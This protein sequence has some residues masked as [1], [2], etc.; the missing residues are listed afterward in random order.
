[1]ANIEASTGIEVGK[2]NWKALLSELQVEVSQWNKKWDTSWDRLIR[3]TDKVK[4]EGEKLQLVRNGTTYEIAILKSEITQKPQ[5]KVPTTKK[6]IL[7]KSWDSISKILTTEFGK[8]NF[9]YGD[10]TGPA[11]MKEGWDTIFVGEKLTLETAGQTNESGMYLYTLSRE[12][13]GKKES[14]TFVS[15]KRLL[16]DSSAWQSG[17]QNQDTPVRNETTSNKR[18]AS[19][20]G[21]KKEWE[22]LEKDTTKLNAVRTAIR[23]QN[24]GIDTSKLLPTSTQNEWI[25]PGKNALQKR[26][27]QVKSNGKLEEISTDTD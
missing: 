3:E 21:D 8:G 24:P 20:I 7:V 5:E 11:K 13:N 23:I 22:N 17:T 26:F 25:L 6:D 9:Q 15:S 19:Y 14:I 12:K 10:K 18:V 27:Y 2:K 4:K 16:S 1:M